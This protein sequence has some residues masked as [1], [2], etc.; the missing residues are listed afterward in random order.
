MNTQRK[1]AMKLLKCGNARVWMDP[2]RAEDI[3]QAI[4]RHDVA[5]LIKD[6][7]IAKIPEKGISSGRKAKARLQKKKGRKHGHGSRKGSKHLKK[8]AWIKKIRALRR[9]M[10]QLKAKG[11]ITNTVYR[12]TYNK[13]KSGF[14]KDK[15]YLKVYLERNKLLKEKK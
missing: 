10:Q 1:I 6:G 5:R 13:S 11:M 4:T 12:E 7:V 9:Y 2:S 14:F 15:N 3:S 8:A